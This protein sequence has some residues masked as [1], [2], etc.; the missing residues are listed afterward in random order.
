LRRRANRHVAGGQE[1]PG[2]DP[3]EKEPDH[4]R[5]GHDR[6]DDHRDR[7]RDDR[8]EHRAGS[9]DRTGIAGPVLLLLHGGEEGGADGR[10]IGD[11]RSAHAR[12]DEVGD[13]G[14]LRKAAAPVPDHG[15]RPID[16]AP[17]HAAAVHDLSG[18]DE[19]RHGNQRGRIDAG[20]HGQRHDHGVS[21]AVGLEED[22]ERRAEDHGETDV[23]AD[24]H[25]REEQDKRDDQHGGPRSCGSSGMPSRRRAILTTRK[26][27][28][29]AVAATIAA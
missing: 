3:G 6:I 28:S 26:N 20:M 15:E 12:H 9:D 22:A 8:P 13:D 16:Q 27:A 19:H 7:R 2:H 4:R 24:D 1:E 23:Q 17:R 11:S 5:I 21:R 14:H 29:S 10:R 25:Q 18:E